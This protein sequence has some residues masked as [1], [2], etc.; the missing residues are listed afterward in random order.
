MLETRYFT[1]NE[2]HKTL[3][4]SAQ[5]ILNSKFNPD[6]I[7]AIGAGGFIPARI[8]R[9]YLK[10]PIITVTIAYYDHDKKKGKV[11]AK[12]QWL[13]TVDIS[14]KKILVVDEVDDSRITLEYTVKALLEENPSELSI[15]VLHNK[16]R[17]KEGCFPDSVK[18][19]FV[20]ENFENSWFCYPWD[21][22]DIDLHK[23]KT[24]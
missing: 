8:L 24:Q 14:N 12:Q 1:Y 11:P 7:V 18:H 20:G 21:A 2:I 10:V 6:Y 3:C 19:V 9:T 5:K 17:E 15:Y 23:E 4:D 16:L 22:T 13:D